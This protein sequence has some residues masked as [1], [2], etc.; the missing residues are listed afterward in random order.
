MTVDPKRTV[1][2]LAY[3]SQNMLLRSISKHIEDQNWFAI[4]IDF[5]I[6]V[7]GV[8]IGIQVANWNDARGQRAAEADYLAALESDTRFSIESIETVVERMGQAQEARRLLY[9][10]GKK[11]N[12]QRP[13]ADISKLLQGA[14]FNIQRLNV[15]QV[16]FDALT[17]SGQLS[18]IDDP[19]LASELQALDT[20][21]EVAQRWEKESIEFT[22]E[23][24]DRYLIAEADAENLMI[25]NLVGDKSNV[26]WIKGNDGPSLSPEKIRSV[27][28]KNLLLYQ[29]E[30]SRG[31]LIATKACLQQYEKVL[32]LILA[33]QSELATR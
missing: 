9:E 26:E 5:V 17:S 25:A 15:R 13:T 22:Y 3:G 12:A 31:R 11:A 23:H 28:L 18:I 27:R 10:I 16:A 14:L 4:G 1:R 24:I 30:I 32:D 33:R 29:A 7:V 21:I 8:F 2:V 6:V 20:A 19:E